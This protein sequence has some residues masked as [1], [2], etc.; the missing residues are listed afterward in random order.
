MGRVACAQEQDSTSQLSSQ[1]AAFVTVPLEF[2]DGAGAPDG[3]DWFAAEP[4]AA[5]EP[6]S[7][8]DAP[9]A[10]PQEHAASP[11]GVLQSWSFAGGTGARATPVQ[12][13]LPAETQTFT[14]ESESIYE[15]PAE[16][17]T[18]PHSFQ[19][20]DNLKVKAQPLG[21]GLGGRVTLTFSFATP[22]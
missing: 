7:R 8:G 14:L 16:R 6:A 22:Y 4:A 17:S 10:P 15:P 5:S 9:A 2:D 11:F 3:D 19:I 12:L 18:E 13:D 20:N 21:G 1:L